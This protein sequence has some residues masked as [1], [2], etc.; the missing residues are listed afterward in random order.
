MGLIEKLKEHK[1][2]R[3]GMVMPPRS[4]RNEIY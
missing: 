1:N 4:K 3:L 2:V